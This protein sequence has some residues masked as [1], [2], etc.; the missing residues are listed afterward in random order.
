VRPASWVTSAN[1]AGVPNPIVAAAAAI[2]PSR[3]QNKRSSV[4]VM[5]PDAVPPPA[6]AASSTSSRASSAG[7]GSGHGAGAA[8]AGPTAIPIPTAP[9][10]SSLS[11]G[12]GAFSATA[13]SAMQAAAATRHPCTSNDFT[14]ATPVASVERP[15][16]EFSPSR[17]SMHVPFP[18]APTRGA[19]ASSQRVTPPWLNSPVF[20]AIDDI[21]SSDPCATPGT[22]GSGEGPGVPQRNA[23]MLRQEQP[24]P[25][26]ANTTATTALPLQ[27]QQQQRQ[28]SSNT[29]GVCEDIVSSVRHAAGGAGLWGPTAHN[30][31]PL[32]PHTMS[33]AAPGVLPRQ[34][35]V[36]PPPSTI[37]LNSAYVSRTTSLADGVA[38]R[39][40]SSGRYTGPVLPRYTTSGDNVPVSME[41][42]TSNPFASYS[43]EL[44]AAELARRSDDS[45]NA[46][47]L[48][49][50]QQQQQQEELQL[51]QQRT[52]V[53][54][55][56]NTD[57]CTT[58]LGRL[59]EEA[60]QTYA[61]A[62]ARLLD[63]GLSLIED[64]MRTRDVFFSAGALFAA[65]GDSAASAR[66]LLHATFINRAFHNDDEALTT[67]A[68]SVDQ[69][70]HAH[71]GAAV[72]ALLRL[73]PCY[74]RKHLRYQAARCYRD[75]AA[76]TESELDDKATAV[77]LYRR[78]LEI[79]ADTQ[80]AASVLARKWERQQRQQAHETPSTPASRP[81]VVGGD[82]SSEASLPA[83]PSASLSRT[84]DGD[85]DLTSLKAGLPPP[86][87]QVSTTVQRSLVEACRGRLLVL[88]A[89]LHRYPELLE[90]ALTCAENVPRALPKTKFLLC[91]TLSVLARGAPLQPDAVSPPCTEGE[92]SGVA[93][94]TSPPPPF[95]GAGDA[96]LMFM[97][98]AAEAADALYF[99]SLYDAEKIF[100]ALQEEDRT[101]QRGK[102]NELVR[103]LLAANKAC[104]LTMFDEAVRKYK[105]YTTTEPNIVQDLLLEQCRRCL[106]QHVERF[107]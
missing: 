17:E 18:Q 1:F 40:R 57:E 78:A 24:A 42:R 84:S 28:Q 14:P 9:K 37:I 87:Y 67:S 26:A 41:Q 34:T 29:N 23:L 93:A 76:I 25:P 7:G 2:T 56:R 48:V 99:D 52:S 58:E 35:F 45:A 97:S 81:V 63:D 92:G 5:W 64:W 62:E 106:F 38:A 66:C 75:A 69:L 90:V 70:K 13:V 3:R 77:E 104:S 79:Y 53:V 27:Q 72:D 101:F 59:L 22:V 15:P 36:P 82:V 12:S 94:T 102:E 68:L 30:G 83:L 74:A 11:S 32:P 16:R 21:D 8:A 61:Q 20:A 86:H 46:G 100:S 60:R 33:T 98:A 43:A 39:R 65:V 107:A 95:N 103:A 47:D 105:V 51:Y 10:R 31:V 85:V 19:S 96:P 89:Q 73:A 4:T 44:L 80:V 6:A 50:F 55:Q 91:A 88:L 49:P 54:L 71:P